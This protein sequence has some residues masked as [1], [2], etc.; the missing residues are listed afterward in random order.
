M[1]DLPGSTRVD[2]R[3]PKEAFY[4]H[5][6]I[7][8][9]LKAKF[10]SDIDRITIKNSLTKENLNLVDDTD[11]KEILVLSIELKEKDFDKKIVEAI[12]RQNPH[13]LLF[14]LRYEDQVQC[15]IYHSKLYCS[16]WMSEEEL[17]LT[18][19]GNSLNE[20]WDD[21]IQQVAIHNENVAK[22]NQISVN[23]EL[24][25]QDR[26]EQ[27]IKNIE[28]TKKAVWKEK[29]PKKKFKLYQDLQA[30]SKELKELTDGQA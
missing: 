14:L 17:A 12:A 16:K 15:V 18:L 24:K 8:A 26:I 19:K 7:S 28:K 22:M 6:S 30:Y 25:L 29:Q 11:I 13:K 3:L 4:K 21:L 10:V 2:R 27:L 23:E 9:A 5:L 1:I 20:I